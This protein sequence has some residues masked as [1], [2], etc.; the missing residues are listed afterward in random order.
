MIFFYFALF[1]LFDFFI[2]FALAIFAYFFNCFVYF[3]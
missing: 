1:I 3:I 2:Q